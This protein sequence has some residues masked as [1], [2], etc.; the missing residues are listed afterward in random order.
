MN[1]VVAVCSLVCV[2][3]CVVVNSCV[4]LWLA[5]ACCKAPTHAGGRTGACATVY[6]QFY[7]G[8]P[9]EGVAKVQ[10]NQFRSDI[11]IDKCRMAHLV[12]AGLRAASRGLELP[13][14]SDAKLLAECP[15]EYSAAS[16]AA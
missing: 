4:V 3:V 5:S 8:V 14:P 7:Y 9:R 6:T 13:M 2:C 11:H 1:I 16:P 10:K 15:N 12:L